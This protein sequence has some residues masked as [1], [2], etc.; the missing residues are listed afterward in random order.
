MTLLESSKCFDCF[1]ASL[2]EIPSTTFRVQPC[3]A[4]QEIVV[5]TQAYQIFQGLPTLRIGEPCTIR[6][7]QS[8]FIMLIAVDAIKYIRHVQ[9]AVNHAVFVQ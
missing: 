4:I 3:K 5:I 1:A 2:L 6:I 7:N 8:E 9:V